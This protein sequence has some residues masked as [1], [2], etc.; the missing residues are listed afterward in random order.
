MAFDVETIGMG[1]TSA[2][3][4][5]A[6][7]WGWIQKQH[8]VVSETKARVAED[9]RDRE[10]ANSAGTL[11]SM[12]NERLKTVEQELRDLKNYSRK[13]E[14]HISKLEGLM[15]EHNITPPILET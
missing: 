8:S 5:A 9:D 1:L 10:M 11:Y 13:L 12:L 6:L 14:L 7:V 3:G 4:I 2:A 15:R